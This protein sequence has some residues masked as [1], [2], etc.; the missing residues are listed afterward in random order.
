MMARTLL[1]PAEPTT[2]GY[3]VAGWY[4]GIN[5]SWARLDLAYRDAAQLQL[6]GPAGTLAHFGDRA[7]EVAH[8][9]GSRLQL[10]VRAPWHTQRDRMAALMAHFGVYTGSLAKIARDIALLMQPEIGEL[11]EPGGGSSSMAHKRNPS[12]CV[13]ALAA[14]SGVP[15][16]VAAYLAAMPQEL[17]RAAGG[18]QS[19][20]PTVAGIV[21]ATGSVLEAVATAVCGLTVNQDRMRANV[22]IPNP[23]SCLGSAEEFRLMLLEDYVR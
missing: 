2:L 7:L 22:T 10:K 19:E 11:A 8:R 5:R 14:A 1:Q 3:K 15:P 23:E 20:L 13:T 6:G 12:H 4:A 18:W 21:Q 16:L 9:V 17:D